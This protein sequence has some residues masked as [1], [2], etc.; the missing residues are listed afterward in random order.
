MFANENIIIYFSIRVFFG[1]ERVRQ[2]LNSHKP[3]PHDHTLLPVFD[4]P[5]NGPN[6]LRSSISKDILVA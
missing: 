6:D 5:C 4:I 2:D 1:G 3:P